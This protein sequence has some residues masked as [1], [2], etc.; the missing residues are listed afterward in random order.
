V[1]DGVK[2]DLLALEALVVEVLLA[3]L[4]PQGK[5]ILAVAVAL[6]LPQEEQAVAVS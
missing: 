5:R 4:A 2:T 3:L 1:V 6:V